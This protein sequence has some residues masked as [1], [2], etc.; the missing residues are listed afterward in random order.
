MFSGE[1]AGEHHPE[2]NSKG[3]TVEEH[4]GQDDPRVHP[5]FGR[6]GLRMIREGDV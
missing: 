2:E 5:E 6:F 4:Y 3:K 1:H